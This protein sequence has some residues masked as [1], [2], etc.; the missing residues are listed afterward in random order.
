MNVDMGMNCKAVERIVR[1]VSCHRRVQ[2]LELLVQ[3][4]GLSLTQISR[5]LGVDFKVVAEHTQRLEA[6]GHLVKRQVG[7][8]VCHLPTGRGE[9]VLGFLRTLEST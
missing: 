5:R 3:D 4:S 6:A 7:R 8:S 9:A 1:G 2:I